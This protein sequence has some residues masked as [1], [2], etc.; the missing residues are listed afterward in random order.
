MTSL[1]Y[2]K[3]SKDKAEALKRFL[4][5]QAL[6][7]KGYPVKASEGCVMFPIKDPDPVLNAFPEVAIENLDVK[8]RPELDL[9]A[10]L[11]QKLTEEQLALLPSGFDT[12]G[13]IAILELPKELADKGR[14]IG[15][16]ILKLHKNIRTVVA[17]ASK[18]QG[19]FRLQQYEVLAGK[20]TFETM[21]K[22]N[23]VRLK[24][25][26]SKVYFT[27]RLAG[28]RLRIAR[29]VKPGERVLVMF[30]GA[31]PYPCVIARNSKAKEIIGI[32]LNP[33]AHNYAVVNKNLNKLH[34]FTPIQGDVREVVPKLNQVFDRILMPLPK[35]GE[36]FLDCA[37]RAAKN[38]TII[39]FY[40]FQPE[41]EFP[42]ATIA[43]VKRAIKPKEFEVLNGVV[44]GSY[45]PGINRV[46]LD[47]RLK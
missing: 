10:I 35:T 38:G 28:E 11:K 3:V 9:R 17:K 25:D 41:Q 18:H 26:I 31:G 44:C 45:A 7:A 47:F 43:K 6:F 33:V 13:T 15:E 21:H 40:D 29:Q 4:L 37:L 27:P 19:E 46:C 39:H 36:H 32:E 8:K 5:E 42:K 12:I 30:S 1:Q 16:A 20:P 14:E 2:A 23:G 34:N 24:L 22:E